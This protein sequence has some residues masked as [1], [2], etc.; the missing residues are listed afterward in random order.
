MTVSDLLTRKSIRAGILA[1]ATPLLLAAGLAP[2]PACAA[3]GDIYEVTGAEKVNLRAGPTEDAAVRSTVTR[4][5]DLLELDS[6]GKWLGVRVLA[7]GQEGWIFSELVARKTASTLR[8]PGLSEA[9]PPTKPAPEIKDAGFASLS[10]HFNALVADLD[11]TFGYPSVQTVDRQENRL[12]VTPTKR[13]LYGTSREA[14]AMTGV[15]LYEMWKSYN[16]GGPV[17]VAVLENQDRPLMTI[18]D[19]DAGPKLSLSDTLTDA[20]ESAPAGR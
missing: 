18:E 10:P 11:D 1:A 19:G 12:I 5:E 9:Q 15:A 4:G 16:N 20:P 3:P 14:K 8:P 6:E 7:N 2:A 13:W 17:A